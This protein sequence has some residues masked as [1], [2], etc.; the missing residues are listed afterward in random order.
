M[1][2]NRS[3]VLLSSGLDSTVNFCK[4]VRETELVMVLTFDYGQRA[5]ESE[6]ARAKKICQKFE[7]RHEILKLDWLKEITKTALVNGKQKL[8]RFTRTQLDDEDL[9]RETARQVWVPNRNALFINIAAS[10]AE[11][12]NADQI[13]VGFNAEEAQTFPDNS[14]AF[15]ERINESLRYSTLKQ[16]KVIS[17]TADLNK[18][19]IVDLGKALGAPFELIWSCYESGDKICG[20]CESCQRYARA[21][22][23]KVGERRAGL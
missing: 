8:P 10:Y 11:H 14:R 7:V 13:V 6:I 19:Q 21:M 15:M 16:P 5:A 12:L 9:T 4:A 22:E 23:V 17:Y 1:S 20:Q 3:L 18:R 2:K